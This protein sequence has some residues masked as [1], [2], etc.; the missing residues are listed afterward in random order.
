MPRRKFFQLRKITRNQALY[1]FLVLAFGCYIIYLFTKILLQS[2]YFNPVER[3][4]FVMYGETPIFYSIGV[5][6]VGNY[7]MPLYPDLRSTIPG[8]YGNYRI[9]ALGKLSILEN[10]TSL[11]QKAFASVTSTF[12]HFYFADV[13]DKIYY[14]KLSSSFQVKGPNIVSILT[15]TSNASF[16][17][18][19][20][21]IGVISQIRNSDYILINTEILNDNNTE[22]T[23]FDNKN[24]QRIY[25]GIFYQ[26]TYRLE[27]LSIQ[28][29]YSNQYDTAEKISTI[30]NGN[31][32]FVSDISFQDYEHD[33]CV[34]I[35]ES[36]EQSKTARRIQHYF[37]CNYKKS[38][39]GL[40][41]IQFVLGDLE[42][43]WRVI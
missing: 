31:G 39:T 4:N 18:K 25:Q 6:E 32:I 40:Y 20:Y 19:L 37:G 24:F 12:V 13:N 30:L 11:F 14:G 8:G 29:I 35:E 16:L 15:Q 28:L 26:D 3:I 36:D 43:S 1:V 5:T 34:I 7:M 17:D 22:E 2:L 21:L 33:R 41:D 10:D 42:K 23:I 38:E 27:N 9:G